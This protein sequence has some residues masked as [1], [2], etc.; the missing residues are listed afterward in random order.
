M[1]KIKRRVVVVGNSAVGKSSMLEF[2]CTGNMQSNYKMTKGCDVR[3]KLVECSNDRDVEL[4]F[5]DMAGKDMYKV[6]VQ[7]MLKDAHFVC[8]TYDSTDAQSFRELDT[9]HDLIKKSNGNRDLSGIIVSTKNDLTTL[10][11]IDK[12]EARLINETNFR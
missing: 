3:S 1:H 4:Y 2:Y 9:W 10:R 6:I 11:E 12:T 8:L 7:K 5:L